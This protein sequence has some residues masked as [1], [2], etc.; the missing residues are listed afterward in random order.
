MTGYTA[1]TAGVCTDKFEAT[2]QTGSNPPAICGI[3]TGYHSEFSRI[4]ECLNTKLSYSS[5][6]R[7]VWSYSHWFRDTEAHIRWHEQQDLEHPGQTDRLH[8]TLEVRINYIF[9]SFLP[10]IPRAPTD[11]TQYFTGVSGNVKSYNFAG[12]QILQSQNYG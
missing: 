9:F 10:I 5:S 8:L 7:R 6:V 3:N 1:T 4:L 11:C 12:S 2:G